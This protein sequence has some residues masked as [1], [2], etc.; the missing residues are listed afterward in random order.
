M[1]LKIVK[2]MLVTHVA[3]AAFEKRL[4]ARVEE[5][6]GYLDGWGVIQD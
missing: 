3:I 5:A 4:E 2:R 1:E 6:D